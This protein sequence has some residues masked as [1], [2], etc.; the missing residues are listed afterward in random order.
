MVA[1]VVGGMLAV[2][3][4]VWSS[5]RS[6]LVGVVGA[7]AIAVLA[8][9]GALAATLVGS[10]VPLA[11][12]AFQGGDGNQVDQ[13]TYVDW[14]GL[15]AA[16]G[17]VH[18]PDP[19]AADSA[20]RGGAKED[21]PGA[22]DLGTESG[23]VN[24]AKDNIL[25][26]YSAV[27]QPGAATFLYLA[28]T[29]EKAD[30]TTFVAFELNQDARL[31]NNGRAQ[32]P[33]RRTGDV[34][35]V[36]EAHGNGMDFVLERWVTSDTD[37]GTGC[38]TTGHLDQVANVPVADAQGA[39]NA[40]AVA[41]YLP[42]SFPVPGTI[43]GAGQFGEAA[44]NLSALL[45]AAFSDRC[46]AFGSIW[47][48]SRSSLSESSQ[49]Q[50]YLAPRPL[51]VRT[52]A[53]AGT[54]FY[55]LNANGRRDRGEPGIPRFLI[56]ADYN[57][58]GQRQANEPFAVTDDR[59]RYVLEDIQP[60]GG[61]YTLRETLLGPGRV[62]ATS[63]V[64]SYPHAGTPG[65]FANGPGGL[66]GCGWGPIATASTPYAHGR[67]FGN[68]LPA[69]LTVRKRLWPPGDPGR[70][71]L[72]V[73]GT[74]VVPAAGDGAITTIPVPPGSYDITEAAVPPTDAGAYRSTVSCRPTTSRRG[75][76]RAGPVYHGLVLV[77]GDQATCTFTNVRPNTP[78]IAIEKT[79]PTVAT[80]GDTLHYTLYV[81]NPG[82]VRLPASTVKVTDP[83]C[84]QP[85]TLVGKA[86]L[87]GTDSSPRTLDPGDTWTY[88][89]SNK[90][91]T[92][93]GDCTQTA[94]TNTATAT[95]TANRTTVR[96]HAS[97]TTTIDCPDQ[98]SQPALPPPTPPGPTPPTPIPNPG[99]TPPAPVTPLGPIPPPA[100]TIAAGLRLRRGC[101][102]RLSQVHLIGT[103]INRIQIK[104][105][106]QQVR[107][108]TLRV[109]QQRASLLPRLPRPGRHRVSVQITFQPGSG[110]PPLTLTHTLNICRP[111]PPT[112][113]GGLGGLG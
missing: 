94:I 47:M 86:D 110:G 99:P 59:G 2:S 113:L 33:C 112:G 23:G 17:V 96:D 53:V 18:S 26:A 88:Q 16:S 63:W 45:S 30:G 56:W 84:D 60:P 106:G 73:N 100:G 104:V 102:S 108:A 83:A 49:L 8:P 10:P 92:P 55:D 77:P 19:N 75:H 68:W 6:A 34:L 22:W 65:G 7:L 48:H 21:Q 46:F 24:P 62:P 70:F 91:A 50:D 3:G 9:S 35:V 78:A 71:D 58:D 80:A 28:F 81:T 51:V 39:V 12:S 29:R 69:Q 101:I 42:G 67:D 61:E 52:C 27:D 85:P 36:F 1:V 14:Q 11:G 38:A 54:K 79:G 97:I 95:A 20:F 40:G 66:F 89:C 41:N 98:P 82:E 13:S 43:P 87:N 109:L 72:L 105:D 32:I 107:Q 4:A 90:T 31:W 103:R 5:L 76:L 57:R 15:Q 37:A 93:P 111:P 64:C 44:L 74:V 25:D